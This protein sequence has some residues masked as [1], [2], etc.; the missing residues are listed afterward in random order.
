MLHI[1]NGDS[2]RMG[3]EQSGIPGRFVVWPDI[4]YEGPTPLATGDEWIAAR[5]RHLAGVVDRAEDEFVEGYRRNDAALESFRDHDEVIFWFEHDLFDQLLLVRHLWWVKERGS[6]ASG[7]STRFSLV[8]GDVYLGPLKPD[9]FPQLFADRRPITGAQIDLGSRVWQ[10]F[11]GEDPTRL[12][13]F[14]ANASPELPFLPAALRRFLEDYPSAANGLTRT[15]QQILRVA[16]DGAI[17][18]HQAFRA[19]QNLED[20]MFMGDLSFFNIVDALATAPHP[21]LIED[22]TIRVTDTGREV[23][24]ARADHIALNGISRFVGGAH[25]TPERHW[26]WTGSSL[27]PATA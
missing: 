13:P 8:C 10:A 2:T 23:F 20:A 6:T 5:T 17:T 7:G 12:V 25:L 18:R 15:E 1:L 11:C 9:E 16:S 3:I 27:L 19:S 14:T 4:L 22:G 24:A 26:R 21:L